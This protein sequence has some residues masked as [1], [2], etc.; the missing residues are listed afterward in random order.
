MRPIGYILL[1]CAPLLS[2]PGAV[3]AILS[4]LAFVAGAIAQ[5][6]PK[7]LPPLLRV[8]V[9][10]EPDKGRILYKAITYVNEP[11]KKKGVVCDGIALVEVDMFEDRFVPVEG[12]VIIDIGTRRLTTLDGKGGNRTV[13]TRFVTTDGKELAIVDV[14]KRVKPNTV[15]AV[16]AN[17]ETPAAEFLRALH[18]DTVV[19]IPDAVKKER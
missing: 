5:E 14:W 3:V 18:P 15:I 17:G 6:T 13:E 1:M 8:V 2:T 4:C 19:V 12:H 9:K 10:T 7:D 11:V 16:S